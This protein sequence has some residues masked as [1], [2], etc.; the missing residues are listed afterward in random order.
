M[1]RILLSLAVIASLFG[2]TAW[3][4]GTCTQSLNVYP[5]NT[6]STVKTVTFVC[7]ADGS[8][9]SYPST[10]LSNE[11]YNAVK[12]WYLLSGSCLNGATGP[13]ASTAFFIS[14]AKQSDL[15]GGSGKS[16][17]VT[18]AGVASKFTPITD[19]VYATSGLVPI[20]ENFTLTSTGNAVNSAIVT[21]VF[22][23]VK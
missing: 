1:K 5:S 7:T 2:G 21:L 8:D 15:L 19:T 9:A 20:T 3:G 11:F 14:T 18:T 17:T 13:T 6:N 12:G 10:A 16:P 22:T 4:A 23:F